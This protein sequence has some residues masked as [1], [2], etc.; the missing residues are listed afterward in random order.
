METKSMLFGIFLTIIMISSIGVVLGSFI[1]GGNTVTVPA[2]KIMVYFT[3]STTDA[4]ELRDA[5][6]YNYQYQ[7]NIT[8][9]EGVTVPNPQSCAVF[10]DSK[11]KLFA[12]DNV[13]AYRRHLAEAA[14][15]TGTVPVTSN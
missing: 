4:L 5:L 14:I 10:A 2:G 12:T 11:I 7:V 9:E 1:T 6:C 8:N 15:N 3:M 13:I